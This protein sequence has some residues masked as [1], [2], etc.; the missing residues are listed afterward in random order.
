VKQRV[1]D[2][3]A[4]AFSVALLAIL[5]GATYYLAEFGDQPGGETGVRPLRHE[6]DYFV[7]HFA[8]TRLSPTGAPMYRM[9]GEKLQHYP[10]DDSSEFSKPLLVSLDPA[11]PLMTLRADRG[12]STAAGEQTQLHDNVL[13]TRAA[14]GT[15]PALRIETD[16]VL[17]LSAE[18]V[19]KTD[20][21]VRIT[22][23]TSSLTGVG[24]EFDNSSR[25]LNVLSNVRGVW[26]PPPDR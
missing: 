25:V 15:T 3:F 7:D 22:Y 12:R 5:A 4:A 18:D 21:P 16:Y 1:Y 9:S 24:M 10:D 13:L 6:P 8:L 19:A 26:T 20:R 11:K 14:Q 2:R 23:G 17:L